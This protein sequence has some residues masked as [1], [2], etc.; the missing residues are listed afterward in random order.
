MIDNDTEEEIKTV[1][2]F[3]FE[4]NLDDLM[5]NPR[6]QSENSQHSMKK[7]SFG[8]GKENEKKN[9]SDFLVRRP[10]VPQEDAFQ[11]FIDS[12]SRSSTRKRQKKKKFQVPFSKE[13]FQKID[14]WQNKVEDD[15]QESTIESYS[16]FGV[17]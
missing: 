13:N 8:N 10:L 14:K 5:K 15:Q 1:K 2:S 3:Q 7:R 16:Q 11:S 4:K 12:S 9:N 17:Y 6:I